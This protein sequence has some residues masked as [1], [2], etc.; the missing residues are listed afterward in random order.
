MHEIETNNK[1]IDTDAVN[2]KNCENVSSIR[3][4]HVHSLLLAGRSPLSEPHS[5]IAFFGAPLCTNALSSR[6]VH[7]KVVLA[8]IS[9]TSNILS[10]LH[11]CLEVNL[12][13]KYCA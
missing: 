11:L 9:C 3:F 7:L 13:A 8:L 6:L 10:S 1:T 5:C 2:L 12:C 4:H